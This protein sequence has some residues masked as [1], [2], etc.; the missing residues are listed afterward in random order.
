MEGQGKQPAPWTQVGRG[1]E[2][3]VE[4]EHGAAGAPGEERGLI[5]H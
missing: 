2:V 4:E 3:K 5:P 1:W